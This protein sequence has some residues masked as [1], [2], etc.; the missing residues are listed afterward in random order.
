[1]SSHAVCGH[2]GVVTNLLLLHEGLFLSLSLSRFLSLYL[3]DVAA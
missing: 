2:R 1:M 3:P